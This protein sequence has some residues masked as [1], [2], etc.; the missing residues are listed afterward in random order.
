MPV[1]SIAQMK[2]NYKYYRRNIDYIEEIEIMQYEIEELIYVFE[3]CEP[4]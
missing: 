2:I 4:S 3:V 1:G